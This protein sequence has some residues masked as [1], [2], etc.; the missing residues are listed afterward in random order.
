[1]TTA[2]VC[3]SARCL[4]SD[5]SMVGSLEGSAT[6]IAVNVTAQF[7][8]RVQHIVSLHG[9]FPGLMR[10]IRAH[11]DVALTEHRP[12]IVTHSNRSAPG[13]DRVWAFPATGSS[14][15]FGVRVALGLGF[16]RVICCGVPLDSSGR[17]YDD[18]RR[19]AVWDWGG[20]G[21]RPY[22]EAWS[23]AAATEFDGRVRSCSGWTR[24]LL[25]APDA[26]A[27]RVA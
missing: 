16:D 1:M 11:M 7:L 8:P 27:E 22:R 5:L 14:S 2:L 6:I 23:A 4:W 24:T 15:L 3:G 26:A 17:F 20:G 9:D 13:I 21:G 25:G 19:P 12:P 18:P 10:Q